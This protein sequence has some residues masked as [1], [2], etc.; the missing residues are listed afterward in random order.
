MGLAGISRSLAIHQLETELRSAFSALRSLNAPLVHYK[1]CS[2]FDSSPAIGSIGRAL[3]LGIETFAVDRV[4]VVVGAPVLGRYCAFGN[5]FARSGLGSP[6]YRLDRHPTMSCHPTTPMDESDLRRIL[7]QQ[8]ELPIGSIDVTC[9]QQGTPAVFAELDRCCARGERVVLFDTMRDADL[10][11]IG[12]ALWEYA[13]WRVPRND[14]REPTPTTFVVGSSGVEYALRSY[15]LEHGVLAGEPPSCSATAVD[16][17]VCVSGSCSP[18]TARQI[19]YACQRGFIQI[20][21]DPLCFLDHRKQQELEMLVAE[22]IK[23]L[24][25]GA[26]VIVHTS[27]GPDDPR[28]ESFQHQ[29]TTR[30]IDTNAASVLGSALGQVL[31]RV[32]QGTQLRRV[33]VTGGDTAGYVARQLGIEALEFVAP[34]APG[35]PLCRIHATENDP[36]SANMEI[37]FKGGQ[38]GHDDYLVRVR[39]PQYRDTNPA[40]NTNH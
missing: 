1:I 11:I 29:L 15:W 27:L 33:V 17:I 2:T 38:V 14:S 18:V 8:T 36:L 28:I 26:S 23:H 25:E 34:I 32:V 24:R 16:S 40:L 5:L 19:R 12:Q 22:T 30:A 10:P 3:E 4:P 6:V 39:D 9:I 7:G 13:G 37:A 31:R 35:S 20:P 21:L